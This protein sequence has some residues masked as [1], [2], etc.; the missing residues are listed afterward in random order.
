MNN[1]KVNKLSPKFHK[2]T[3]ELIRQNKSKFLN[4]EGFNDFWKLSFIDQ[5]KYFKNIIIKK[6]DIKVIS[7]F[8]D[9]TIFAIKVNGKDGSFIVI[10]SNLKDNKLN[11]K[12]IDQLLESK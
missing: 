7:S 4:L 12:D 11:D 10:N 6:Y 2:K 1:F 3:V 9:R 5:Q 8:N